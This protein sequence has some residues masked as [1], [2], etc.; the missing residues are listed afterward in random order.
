MKQ[1][2]LNHLEQIGVSAGDPILLAVS[3]GL[4]S[5]VML[6]LFIKCD[7]KIAV[8]HANFQLRAHESDEDEKFVEQWCQTYQLPFF[9]RRFNTNNYATARKI[10]IQMAARELRYDWFQDLLND[11]FKFVATA[12]HLNDSLETTILN[13]SRGMGLEGLTGIA[14][15]SGH[16]IRPLLFATRAEIENYAA[17]HQI[18][19]REDHS[20]STDA[21]Q[22]NFIRHQIIP[23]LKIINPSLEETF[24]LSSQRMSEEVQILKQEFETWAQASVLTEGRF[25]KIRKAALLPSHGTIRLDQLLRPYGFNYSQCQDIMAGVQGPVGK[26]VMSGSHKLTIDREFLILTQLETDWRETT[27]SS[28]EQVTSLGPWKMTIDWEGQP[29]DHTDPNQVWVDSSRLQFPL[30]WRKWRPGDSFVPLGMNNRKKISDFLIDK[31]ISGGE[32]DAVTVLESAGE[33]VWVVGLRLD[34]RFKLSKST[35]Q[36]IAFSVSPQL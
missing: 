3:G 27:I 1:K 17:I 22:R 10:S 6:H 21:Y 4:D 34:N 35:S 20:N 33:I 28:K 19:W 25:I 15:R 29:G 23:R 36:A 14:A 32:K 26:Y 11:Q 8:A 12:H 5:M 2:F 30:C 16:R 24:R 7:R 13:L 18:A 9:N 31:K